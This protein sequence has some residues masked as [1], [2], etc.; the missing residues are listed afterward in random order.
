MAGTRWVRLDT[1]YFTNPKISALSRDARDLHLASIVWT[2]EHEQDG[3][4]PAHV[5]DALAVMTKVRRSAMAKAV[6][7]LVCAGLWELNGQGW[8][9]HDF[10]VMN[11][12]VLKV[13]LDAQRAKW[14]ERKAKQ[15]G[16]SHVESQ[17]DRSPE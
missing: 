2:A 4:V 8:H 16:V 11:R 9:V 13:E 5:L 12:Q 6:E 14:A 10:E 15:R 1:H 17:G 7:Q 3:R